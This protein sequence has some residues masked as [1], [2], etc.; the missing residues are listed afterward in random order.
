MPH[1]GLFTQGAM[2]LTER[3]VDAD[4]VERALGPFT[5]GKR[6]PAE[7]E[8]NWISG[9]PMWLVPHRREVNGLIIVE[10]VD[11]PW[12]D[13]MGDPRSPD[14]SRQ[15]LFGAWSMGFMGP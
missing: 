4:S 15:M 6:R 5:V 2:V 1:K 14:E 9:Y 12:P 10:I 7:G 8:K 11:A 13:D 3:V